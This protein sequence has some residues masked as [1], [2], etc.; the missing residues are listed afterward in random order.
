MS[1]AFLHE[2]FLIIIVFMNNDLFL[3][4]ALY[5]YVDMQFG[6]SVAFDHPLDVI[7]ILCFESG[8]CFLDFEDVFSIT[9]CHRS[10]HIGFAQTSIS[11]RW[12]LYFEKFRDLVDLLRGFGR[13]MRE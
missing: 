7:N 5:S 8:K 9:T 11:L 12:F 2:N 3:G 1:T 6:L 4:W 13:D 10:L